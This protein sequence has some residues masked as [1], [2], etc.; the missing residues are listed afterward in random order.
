MMLFHGEEI[1]KVIYKLYVDCHMATDVGTI[2][3]DMF[4][5]L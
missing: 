4:H 2:G 5:D 1:V 3:E